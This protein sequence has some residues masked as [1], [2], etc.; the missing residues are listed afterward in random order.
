MPQDEWVKTE[1]GGPV[2]SH[3]SGCQDEEN[4]LK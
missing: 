2:F 4:G 3:G 1:V